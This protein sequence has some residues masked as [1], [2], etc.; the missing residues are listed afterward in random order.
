MRMHI[1]FHS[2]ITLPK[3]AEADR[4]SEQGYGNRTQA[5]KLVLSLLEACYLHS[6][7]V[8]TL[9][10]AK[11]KPLTS[12]SL[13]RKCAKLQP[14]F[15]IREAVYADL[16]SRGYVVKTALK[17]G[18]D[19]RV[20]DRGVKPGDDHSKWIVYPVHESDKFNW[21]DFTAKNRIAHT[22]KKRLM[23]GI[24]DDEGEVI[25]YEVRW[26]RP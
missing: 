20:Y 7:G 5:G 14:D 22:T 26:V 8:I 18:A 10:D 4:L 3:G 23:L 17:Y 19:F 1:I 6:K 16:R 12:D 11:K 24:V 9:T 13:E 25:Y 2:R 21:R 15:W